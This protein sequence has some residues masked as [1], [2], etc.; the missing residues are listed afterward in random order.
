MMQER[1]ATIL[2]LAATKNI[3]TLRGAKATSPNTFSI[4]TD[5]SSAGHKMSLWFEANDDFLRIE[6]THIFGRFDLDRPP[7]AWAG[8]FVKMLMLNHPSVNTSCAYLAAKP[9]NDA[10]FATLQTSQVFL[11]KWTDEDIAL[12]LAVKFF[13]LMTGLVNKLPAPIEVFS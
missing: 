5:F 13:D 4:D 3:P 6:V 2:R 9:E 7:E 1:M 12:A 10:L 11:V 8:N